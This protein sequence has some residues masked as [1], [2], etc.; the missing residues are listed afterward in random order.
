M[1]D[2]VGFTALAESA[3]PEQVKNLLDRCFERLVSDIGAFGG[4][5]DKIVGDEI[6]AQFGAPIAHEDDAERAVRAALQ[7]TQT[8]EELSRELDTPIALRIGINT[9][10][11]FVGAMKAGGESTVM[12]DVVNTASR[13]QTGARPGQIV[14]G[15]ITQEATRGCVA[16]AALGALTVKGREEPIDAWIALE[17][18]APPGHRRKARKAPLVGRESELGTLRH[19]LHLSV[20]R[21]RSHLALLIGDA[22]VG[23]T[24]LASELA[25][26]AQREHKA[27]VLSGQCA[28]Y[29][30]SGPWAPIAEMIR[31]ACGTDARCATGAVRERLAEAAAM[32]LR[33]DVD[34]S[35]VVR[36]A[37][38]LLYITEGVSRPG[39]D[40]TRARDDALRAVLACLEGFA[41]QAPL[42]VVLS[43]LHWA[44]D[45][46]LE[47]L[48]RLLARLRNLPLILVGTARPGFEDRWQPAPGRHNT[49]VVH[50][51][52]LDAEA[53]T[54]LVEALLGEP[55]D[56][57]VA[58]FVGD[59]SGGNPF[60]VEEL[61]ALLVESEESGPDRLQPERVQGL[62]ATL[63]GLV[64]ARLD[65][66]PDGDR[67]VLEDFAVVGPSGPVSAA[68]ALSG[69]AESRAAL[70]RLADRDLLVLDGDDYRFKSALIRDVAYGTLTKA[71]RARRH[72]ALAPLL[73]AQG[74]QVTEQ[75]AHHLA[76]AAELVDELG[77]VDGVSD[78]IRGLAID[79]LQR[80]ARRAEDSEG[81][82]IAGRLHDR[83]LSLIGDDDD[84]LRLPSLLGRAR[85]RSAQRELDLALHDVQTALSMARSRADLHVEAEALLLLGGIQRNAGEYEEAKRTYADVERRF[86]DLGD[87]SGIASTK[88]D[89]GFTHLFCGETDEAEHLLSQALASFR[90][91]G[92][93]RGVAWALQNLAWI[94]FMRG[95]MPEADTRLREAAERFAEAGDWGGLGWAFGL[96]AFVRYHQGRLDEAED[97]AGQIVVEVRELGNPWAVGMM[98]ALLADIALWRGRGEEAVR[99]GR[100]S[101][102]LFRGIADR[103]GEVQACGV[104]ARA[105]AGL[106]RWAEYGPALAELDDA[107]A[108]H[109]DPNQ[110]LLA[111]VVSAAVAFLT[112]DSEL[113]LP[114]ATLTL[115]DATS[116]ESLGSSERAGALGGA[117][118]QS[119]RVDEALA[120]LDEAFREARADGPRA[121][122]GA[123]LAL[124]YV[125][126]GLPDEATQLLGTVD[127]IDGGTYMD[128]VMSHWARGFVSVQRGDASGS[129]AA[130]DAA[131]TL[132]DA[133]DLR[134]D[135]AVAAL[136]RGR[137]LEAIGSKEAATVL[138]QA[139]EQLQALGIDAAGWETV[140]ALACRGT[141]GGNRRGRAERVTG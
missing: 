104:V 87:E 70:V 92:D 117:L 116:A 21:R 93:D 141:A 66:L 71:E 50:L 9:G 89:L 131:C 125:A 81:W 140:F 137:A 69:D 55:V 95:R 15:P 94:A 57:S 106:G 127:A 68:L 12:G 2:L 124:A 97:L 19:A 88:R 108:R 65:A 73:A 135:I 90:V 7:M 52:P 80:A 78:D 120:V 6:V 45:L 8:V 16:Y 11:V 102:T 32:A 58:A 84:P 67:S 133:T 10:E 111:R 83:T 29:G 128:R 99:R 103:F 38:G 23:K 72:A 4:K 113:A 3:D 85:A 34:D 39:V 105:L 98:E 5:L 75:V 118:L 132:T 112:G 59:R 53:T 64:A 77:A 54:D 31:Q 42:V 139:A 62:P 35:E 37:E 114:D 91:F 33:R 61:V 41:E 63:H 119:G 30:D 27:L 25:S 109:P 115:D 18:T 14:V 101:L 76:V 129:V 126:G 82:L 46:V 28:P 74:D 107:A 49:L 48:N 44:D 22:G 24:R 134:V 79:A 1:A 43:D 17:V 86:H 122:L 100:E 26:E 60:F 110:R 121:A 138:V 96:L 13:L 136:A 56:S 130:F 36:A 40:P 47:A 51:D 123:L 20:T